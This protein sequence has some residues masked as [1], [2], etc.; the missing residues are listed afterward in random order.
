M[1]FREILIKLIHLINYLGQIEGSYCSHCRSQRPRCAFFKE[2]GMFN[3]GRVESF[4]APPASDYMCNHAIN[5]GLLSVGKMMN[6][7]C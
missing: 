2:V 3:C 6:L 4:E 5:L 1:V 7:M